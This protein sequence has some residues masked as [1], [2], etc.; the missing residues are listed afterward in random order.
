MEHRSERIKGSLRSV[1][2]L[3]SP[4]PHPADSIEH[5]FLFTAN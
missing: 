5:S 3:L 2:V 1:H 4:I